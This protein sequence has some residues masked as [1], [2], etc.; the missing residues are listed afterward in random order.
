MPDPVK[1]ERLD[2]ILLVTIDNPPVNA[3]SREVLDALE[4]ALAEAAASLEIAALVLSGAG[5]TFVAGADIRAFPVIARGEQPMIDFSATLNRVEAFSKPVVAAL[6]GPVLGGGLE[7]AMA[8]HYRVAAPRSTFGQPEVKLGLI[9]GA[10]GTQRLPRLIGAARAMEL[11]AFGETIGEREALDLGLI[12]EIAPAG[13]LEAA[14]ACARRAGK[15]RRTRDFDAK[16]VAPEQAESLASLVRENVLKKLRL[17]TAPLAALDAILAACRLPFHEGLAAEARLFEECLRGPQSAALIHCFFAERAVSKVSGVNRDTPAAEVTRAAVIGAG[18][19]GRGIATAFLSAGIPVSLYDANPEA[20]AAGKLAIEQ[21]IQGLVAK[22]RLDSAFACTLS[23]A[24]QLDQAVSGSSLIV[25]AVF[26]DPALKRSV[27]LALDTLAPRDCLLAT[28][29]STLDIDDIASATSRPAQVLGLHFFSPAHI[30]RL[31]EIVR[32][33]QTSP[34]TLATA[35]ALT[36]RLRKTAVVSTNRYGFIGNRMFMPYREQAV[37]VALEGASP[38]QVDQALTSWGMAMGPLAVGDLSGLDV[39]RLMRLEALRLGFHYETETFEDILCRQGRTGQKAGAGWYL[40]GS[41]RK[42]LPDPDVERE[43]RV[44][45]AGRGISQHTFTGREIRF[46][47]LFAMINEGARLLEEGVAARA[48]D[49]DVVYTNGYGF[50]AWRGG[51]M[52]TADAIG[53]NVVFD[54]LARFYDERGKF[55]KPSELIAECARTGRRLAEW[56]R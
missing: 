15:P 13:L 19:M 23:A 30:M 24:A 39:F 53:L 37:D 10:G 33:A 42:P 54:T 2:S 41:D 14:V 12:D 11:C 32:G 55:W 28:N 4:A 51:P 34:E 46:R 26:E 20:L 48:S 16:L 44:Y 40:Y 47:T 36:K 3:L 50:P 17:Q 7:L 43:L 27:F 25:E 31:L 49:L 6:Q 38:E 52:H 9:P 5:S 21:T 8:C 35:L 29:T 56:S 18:T 45:A 1:T 22:G